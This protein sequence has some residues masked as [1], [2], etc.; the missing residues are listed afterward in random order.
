MIDDLRINANQYDLEP[1]R[2]TITP[3]SP[4]TLAS[5]APQTVTFT[6]QASGWNSFPGVDT[7][8]L[9][10]RPIV[11]GYE[12]QIGFRAT[13]ATTVVGL[14]GTVPVASQFSQLT[15]P[16]PPITF[17]LDVTAALIGAGT[18]IAV[19]WLAPVPAGQVPPPTPGVAVNAT[20][21]PA[22][23]LLQL[24]PVATTTTVAP[25]TTAPLT[26]SFTLPATG[27]SESS[28]RLAWIALGA[29]AIGV[30][31][32]MTARRRVDPTR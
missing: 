4:V 20:T 18:S 8:A 27:P 23:T 6:L 15:S 29:V 2:V 5:R 28:Q 22:T 16:P 17:T 1:A 31:L 10:D 24:P 21:D 3:A 11:G 12:M 32:V 26:P 13:G 9:V 25:T 19:D 7:T 30:I 14:A